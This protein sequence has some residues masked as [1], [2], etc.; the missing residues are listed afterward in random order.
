MVRKKTKM[1]SSS[2]VPPGFLY[3]TE[4]WLKTQLLLAFK[5][6]P[7]RRPYHLKPLPHWSG[8]AF[9]WKQRRSPANKVKICKIKKGPGKDT[10]GTGDSV[11]SLSHGFIY[12]K[13]EY[14]LKMFLGVG[15]ISQE[16]VRRGGQ[17]LGRTK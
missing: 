9:L 2:S 10:V 5:S 1:M 6:C 16:K 3:H 12:F 15:T 8:E 7:L 14:H 13:S 17:A 4:Q 11:W